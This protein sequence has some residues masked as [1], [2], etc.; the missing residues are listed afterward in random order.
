MKNSHKL[1]SK[2][3]IKYKMFVLKQNVYTMLSNITYTIFNMERY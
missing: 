1:K 3:I 2:R